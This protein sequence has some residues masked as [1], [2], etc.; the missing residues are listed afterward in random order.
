MNR[1]QPGGKKTQPKDQNKRKP[2]TLWYIMPM[3]FK[4]ANYLCRLNNQWSDHAKDR[5]QNS[6]SK[7][8]QFNAISYRTQKDISNLKIIS[9]ANLLFGSRWTH[10]ENI[11][12]FRFLHHYWS[13]V[14]DEEAQQSLYCEEHSQILIFECEKMKR[15]EN[16]IKVKCVRERMPIC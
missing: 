10:T 14:D 16:K 13:C 7:T 3:I 8:I 2:K 5:K 12:I 11:I 6:T 9:L 4:Q 15:R 1:A